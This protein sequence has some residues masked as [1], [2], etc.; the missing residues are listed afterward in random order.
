MP[1][2]AER[3]QTAHRAFATNGAAGAP[4][5]L[6]EL[7]QGALVRFGELGFPSTRLE[8]W[9]FTNVAPIAETPFELAGAPRS[10]LPPLQ[11]LEPHLLGDAAP[12]RLVFVNG[13]FSDALSQ[14]TG[15]PDG[16]RVGS[17]A[18]ALVQDG[19]LVRRH[20]GRIAGFEEHAFRALNTAFLADG[21]FIYVPAGVALAQP[22][23]LLF[24]SVPGAAPHVAHPRNLVVVEREARAAVIETYAT[25][26]DGVYWTNAVTEIVV[27]DG[28]RVDYHR[29]QRESEGAYHVASTES[30]QGR[31]STLHV[32]AVAFGAALARHDL[33]AALDG[34]GG[35]CILNGLYLL[36]GLQHVDHH[37]VIDHRQPHC[38]SHEYFNGVLDGGARSVFTGRIIVRPGAQRTDSKQTNNNLLLSGDAHADSQPQL[39]IYA[40]DVKCTHGST[41]GPVDEGQVFY[42]KSRGLDGEAARRLLTYGFG[43]EILARI[44][45][46][47]LREQLDRAVRARVWA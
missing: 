44:A 11:A 10:A 9:R 28:A 42:L 8:A 6:R 21:A 32:H 7:R 27:G 1:G 17:L 30:S 39:E 5:W 31:D 4:P 15:L 33:R 37:T 14:R 23:Q 43:A 3:Y 20:L 24:L 2:V 45:I 47:P 19:E 26:G 18:A 46:A 13:H 36:R 22:V 40:D 29:V 16:V 35:S 41:L 34:P 38:E 25:L 12:H